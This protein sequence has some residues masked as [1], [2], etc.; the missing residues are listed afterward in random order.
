V[1]TQSVVVLSPSAMLNSRVRFGR[2]VSAYEQDSIEH[3]KD[4]VSCIS[5][6]FSADEWNAKHGQLCWDNHNSSCFNHPV[7][8]EC[9]PI[10]PEKPYNVNCNWI[11]DRALVSGGTGVDDK[12]GAS[13]DEQ[14]LSAFY[15][16]LVTVTTVGYVSRP[17][18][19]RP[20]TTVA[21]LPSDSCRA[22]SYRKHQQRKSSLYCAS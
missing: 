5:P 14:Y 3:T 10:P 9:V 8:H 6:D 12:V 22:I 7:C 4:F 20:V 15:F 18:A 21:H 13:E 2:M 17:H 1:R 11:K 19:C 16:S